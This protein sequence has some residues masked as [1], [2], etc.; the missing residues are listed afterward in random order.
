METVIII[1]LGIGLVILAIISIINSRKSSDAATSAAEQIR[2]LSNE[3]VVADERRAAAEKALDEASLRHTSEIQRIAAE[4]A[5]NIADIR[6][7]AD[8]LRKSQLDNAGEMLRIQDETGETRIAEQKHSYERQLDELRQSYIRQ[9]DELKALH[10]RQLAEVR[11]ASQKQLDEL[12][13]DNARQL[14]ELREAHSAQLAHERETLGERFKAIASDILQANSKQLDEHSRASLE[15]ALSPMKTSLEEFTK[16][17]RECYAVENRDRLSM[18][19]EI[20]ALHELNTSVGR[21]AGKLASALKGNTSVQGKWGEMVLA[22]ILEHS[23]LQQGRWFVTQETTTSGEGQRLRPD[24]VIHCPK[25]RDIIIDSKVSL[26]AYLSMLDADTDEER[27]LLMKAHLQSVEAHIKE[28]RDKE[29]HKN[30]G[31]GKGDFVLMFM[32]H[33]GAY[34]AAMNANPELWQKAYDGHV[35]IVSPTHLVTVVRLIEQMWQTEDQSVNSQKIAETAETLLTSLT[36]FFTDMSSVGDTLEKAQKTYDTA[37][38]RLKSGNNNVVRVATRLKDLGVK[39]KKEIPQKL[40]DAD[41]EESI[42]IQPISPM[43]SENGLNE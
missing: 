8:A 14:D 10:A 20:K 6:Q 30:I 11:D 23:G 29:Y 37:L 3:R 33:E 26:T 9:L 34:I 25:D 27:A 16:G 35:V 18:R 40:Q 42:S 7:A 22:N 31:A 32:P 13:A 39:A 12:R 4:N 41:D 21:E 19:E 24:A 43:K 17:Y 36:A 5:R 28:L 38:K 15:A 2:Q 1:L